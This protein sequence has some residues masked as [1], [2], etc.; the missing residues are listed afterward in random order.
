MGVIKMTEKGKTR[1][2]II[3]CPE[4]LA[5]KFKEKVARDKTNMTDFLIQKIKE[6]VEGE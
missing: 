4:N 1:K 5:W 2:I 3:N 6:Y